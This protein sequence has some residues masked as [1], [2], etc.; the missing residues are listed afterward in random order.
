MS[1]QPGDFEELPSSECSFE[2]HRFFG[3]SIVLV[4]NGGSD[5]LVASIDRHECFAVRT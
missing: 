4:E 1:D 3:G 2:P 5:G